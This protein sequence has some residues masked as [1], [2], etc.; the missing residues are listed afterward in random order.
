MIKNK[1][2]S[3][4]FG[5]SDT[6]F[7]MGNYDTKTFLIWWLKKLGLDKSNFSNKYT[8]AGTYYEHRIVKL[9]ESLIGEKLK[10]DRQVKLRHLRLRV[11]LDSESNK[12]IYEIKTTSKEVDK[13]P[14]N[15]WQQVQVQMFVTKKHSAKI[16]FYLVDENYYDNYF[17]ELEKQRLKIF[18]IEYDS[19]FINNYL[20]R[21]KY[22]VKCLKEKKVPS[23]EGLENFK[24]E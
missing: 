14:K 4:W 19:D 13:V 5:A 23:N 18:K 22:L 7:I 15:Y 24:G 10:V 2:R 6:S 21:L 12:T 8:M 16:V 9:L 11:N 17:L 1:D 20:I 3:K